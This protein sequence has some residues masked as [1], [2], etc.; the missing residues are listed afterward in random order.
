MA[1][2]W[3]IYDCET[4]YSFVYLIFAVLLQKFNH[5]IFEVSSFNCSRDT[6]GVTKFQK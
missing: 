5:A 4:E 1:Y 6:E 3:L 2:I